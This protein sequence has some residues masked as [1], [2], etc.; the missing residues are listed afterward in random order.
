VTPQPVAGIDLPF[1]P[2]QVT[3]SSRFIALALVTLI[4][5][6]GEE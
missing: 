4:L 2:I 5:L 3:N 6:Y 1:L